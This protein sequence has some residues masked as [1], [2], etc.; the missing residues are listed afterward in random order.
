MF[1]NKADNETD[2]CESYKSQ[3][4]DTNS[5]KDGSLFNSML[6]IVTILFLLAIIVAL[7]IYGY[8]YFINTQKSSVGIVPPISVQVSDEELKV[9]DEP[10]DVEEENIIEKTIEEVISEP[11]VTPPMVKIQE[12]DIDKIANDIKIAIAKSEEE[13][14]EKNITEDNVS[15]EERNLE[16]PTA[17]PEA[18]YL[19]ELAD[20]SK[21]ID[22][23]RK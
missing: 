19:E 4:L 7:S 3:I 6:K 5:S 22:K 12:S 2:F 23:E 10:I 21:E 9:I 13:E 20:L 14:K 1:N 18:K 8:N 11:V 15:V 16:V 17:S